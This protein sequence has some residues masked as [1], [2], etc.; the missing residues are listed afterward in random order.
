MV[1][2]LKTE[3]EASSVALLMNFY[4]TL[5]LFRVQYGRRFIACT[6]VAFEVSLLAAVLYDLRYDVDG[7]S[8][9]VFT[10]ESLC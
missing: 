7:K 10:K 3:N 1:I 4:N 9:A 5:H 6:I 8:S 2:F